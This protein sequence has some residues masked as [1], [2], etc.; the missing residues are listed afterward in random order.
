M[1]KVGLIGCGGIGSTHAEC[2]KLLKDT[3]VT[4]VADLRGDK[5]KAVASAFGAQ[6]FKDGNDLI[7][8]GGFDVIDICLPTYLH[9][10]YALS[11]MEKAKGVFIEKPLC[12]SEAECEKLLKKQ[13]E[14]GCIVQV[15]HVL[16][17]WNE[18]VYLKQIFDSKKYGKLLHAN[19]S[20]L[21]RYPW[22]GWEN[23]FLDRNK[24]GGAALDLH[25]HDSDIALYIFG[26]PN[27]SR[28]C[29]YDGEKNSYICTVNEYEGFSARLEGGWY[30][31]KEFPFDASFLAAFERAAL[32]YSQGRLTVYP[33]GEKPF[34]PEFGAA[35]GRNN[36]GINVTELSGYYNE[37]SAFTES[38]SKK[39]P[40]VTATL[41]EAVETVRT[42]L[43]EI[44]DSQK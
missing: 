18:Y 3:A 44:A 1:L 31:S 13:R 8:S 30:F 33:S 24:S 23:W 29:G 27:K 4:A 19:F 17:F 16:R 28:S 37:L 36:A 43:S 6:V 22:W 35:G 7:A 5:A 20:R 38:V 10:E 42:V 15:G 26:K 9:C 14:T 39:L 32:V 41:H 2:Y 12:L 25:I 34:A 40:P 21:S 11:A